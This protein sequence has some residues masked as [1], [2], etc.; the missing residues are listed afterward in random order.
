MA[1]AM[2]IVETFGPKILTC[3]GIERQAGRAFGEYHGVERYDSFKDEGVGF[4]LESGRLAEVKGSCGVGRAV[5]ILSTRVAEVDG[6]GVNGA[7]V[8]TLRAVMDDCRVG[9]GG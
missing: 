3:Q 7:T 4:S 9:G 1:G 6:F 8:A 5:K 2:S